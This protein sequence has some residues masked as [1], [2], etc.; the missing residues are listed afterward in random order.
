MSAARAA[1][2]HDRLLNHAR[3]TGQDFNVVL[4]RYALERFVYRLSLTPARETLVLKGGLLFAL[5]FNAP[6]RPTRDADF[7]GFGPP[8]VEPLMKTM[9]HACGVELDDGMRFDSTTVSVAPIREEARYGGLRVAL[10]GRLGNA[11]CPLQIDVGFGDAVTPGPEEAV[12][13]SLL[14]DQPA[15]RLRVYPRATVV[16]EKFESIVTLG[17]TNSRLKDYYDLHALAREAAVEPGQLAEAIAAT[18]T[19]RRTPLPAG[20]PL[21]LSDEFATGPQA[22]ARWAGFLNR[23]RIAGPP[24]PD[25]V[26]EI[27]AFL[28][29][30][31]RLALSL[32]ATR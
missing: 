16:A 32:D 14:A 5:W 20:I 12:Y 8:D 11:R 3:S 28:D 23:N 22:R 18:F 9:R 31:L 6:H 1:S 21:G 24:L 4:A 15:A 2:I 19:R 27:R 10:L 29:A 26:S 17:M 25:A 30:P 13:P 7:L